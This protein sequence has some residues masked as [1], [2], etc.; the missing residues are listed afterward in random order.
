[1][2]SERSTHSDTV[3]DGSRKEG[4]KEERHGGTE[5]KRGVGCACLTVSTVFPLYLCLL[6]AL[7]STDC[8]NAPTRV[9]QTHRTEER[10]GKRDT[11]KKGRKERERRREGEKKGKQE[12]RCNRAHTF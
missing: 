5:T 7:H 9:P 11:Q 10:R 4:R 12:A 3:R 6:V 2:G 1:M 8:P